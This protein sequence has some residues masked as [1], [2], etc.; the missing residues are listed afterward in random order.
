MALILPNSAFIHIP[1]TGGTWVRMAIKEL[2]IPC[3]ESGNQPKEWGI[4]TIHH[5]FLK[6]KPY[7]GNKFTFSFVRN[8][9]TYLQ[10]RWCGKSLPRIMEH[11]DLKNSTDFNEFV[12]VYLDKIPGNI[13]QIFRNYLTLND[14]FPAVD[15][16]GKHENL[17]E[18][19]IYVLKYTGEKFNENKLRKLSK[20]SVR[21]TRSNK[22]N[23]EYESENLKLKVFKADELSFKTFNYDII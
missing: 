14:K 4:K 1:Q 18:D 12:K 11:Y 6:A 10:S 7:I 9:L 22:L 21:T 8:P 5:N 13:T 19:L 16:V 17:L 20:I 2:G 3:K 23:C 15:F